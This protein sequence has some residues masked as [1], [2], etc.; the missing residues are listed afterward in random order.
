MRWDSTKKIKSDKL[1]VAKPKPAKPGSPHVQSLTTRDRA[2]K[3][4]LLEYAALD[5]YQLD[6][7]CGDVC[8]I[9]F[10]IVFA[11]IT[12]CVEE[13]HCPSAR[14]VLFEDYF[15][16]K[17]ERSLKDSGFCIKKC[18]T[19]SGCYTGPRTEIEHGVNG[20]K[21]LFSIDHMCRT[22]HYNGVLALGMLQEKANVHV[23]VAQ[24]V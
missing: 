24:K 3:E 20:D 4:F 19:V 9:N 7:F 1:T 17:L 15:Q 12:N 14:K 22:M 13:W 11:A 16:K 23:I 5:P 10:S 21:H 18:E 8:S 6:E 2:V